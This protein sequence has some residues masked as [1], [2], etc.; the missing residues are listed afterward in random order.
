MAAVPRRAER[1]RRI[2]WKLSEQY[3]LP[4][5]GELEAEI[6]DYSRPKKWVLRWRDGPTVTQARRAAGKLDKEALEDV[7]FRRE[8]SDMAYAVA[9]IRCLREGDPGQDA[10]AASVS[11][12]GARRLLDTTKNPGPSDDRERHMAVRLVANSARQSSVYGDGDA[13]CREATQKGLSPLLRGED[14]PPLTPIELLTDRYASGR[15]S[16]LWMYRLT[17]MTALEAFAAVQA[18]DKASS[19]HVAAALTL[20]PELHA[21]L[22]AAAASL[23]ARFPPETG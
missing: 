23:Q 2:A 21:A 1:L 22:D 12:Y 3:G 5:G 11:L 13:I 15:A 18:D 16:A 17:P 7:D 14:A 6:D 9:A 8:Y 10:F 19:E 20:L 4:R